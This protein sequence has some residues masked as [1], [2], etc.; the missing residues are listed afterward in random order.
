MMITAAAWRR[1]LIACGL[2]SVLLIAAFWPTVTILV[3]TWLHIETY[4]HGFLILP[5]SLWLA[6]RLRPQLA[7]LTPRPA[8]AVLLLIA[9]AAIGWGLARLLGVQ[10]VEQLAFVAVWVAALWALL[11]HAVARRLAFPL[12]FLF[13]MVPMG[14]G[15]VPPMMEF[16]AN[17][18]V[19]MLQLTGIPVYR[20]GL[21]FVIPS[22]NWSVVEACSGVR[23]L[24]ASG[25][26]GLLYAYLTYRAMWRRL[27][28]V[29]LALLVPILAN[30]V[31]AYLIVMIGHLSDMR[32]AVGVDHLIY[33]WLF[34]GLV[35]LLLFWIGNLWAEPLQAEAEAASPVPPRPD[36]AGSAARGLVVV[37]SVLLLS[38]VVRIGTAAIAMPPDRLPMVQLPGQLQGWRQME[39]PGLDW[40]FHLQGAQQ[41]L[42][43]S[44]AK[45][46]ARVALVIGLFHTQRQDAEVVNS[47]NRLLKGGDGAWRITGHSRLSL[48]DAAGSLQVPAYHLTR[49]DS[50]L[51]DPTR[52]LLAVD[53]Y[54][55]AGR[56]TTSTY[57]GKWYQALGLLHGRTDGAFVMLATRDDAA[58]T[59]N[60]QAFAREVL[61][62][63]WSAWE[64]AR[65]AH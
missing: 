62:G 38:L 45:G 15:L 49:H 44:Y 58:A 21:F 46:D 51:V 36:S 8:P 17:F 59:A 60:L 33:G 63:I 24:I 29:V 61:P 1:T 41:I 52:R 20:E 65:Q 27:L 32:L 47:E 53:W 16:T 50:L 3:E 39:A 22:G 28:F 34:F 35:M 56:D 11:G 10:L 64:Q 19:F 4:S 5:I 26:L 7:V 57:L 25:T 23:Y 9:V 13:L 12:L 42:R 6:W 31:R 55:L 14:D 54:R 2:I 40:P 30:G 43:A 18:T 37:A 48:D